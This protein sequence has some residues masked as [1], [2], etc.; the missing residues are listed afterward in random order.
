MTDITVTEGD[1]IVVTHETENIGGTTETQDVVLE[2]DG[3]II[4]TD[5]VVSGRAKTPGTKTE[6]LLCWNTSAG[7]AGSYELCC[8]TSDTEDCRTVG[9]LGPVPSSAVLSYNPLTFSVGDSEW[10]DRA[11]PEENMSLTGSFDAVQLSNGGYAVQPSSST[12]NYGATTMPA[13]LEGSSL[14]NFAVEFELEYSDGSTSF[15]VMGADNNGSSQT[16]GVA[17]NFNFS[18]ATPE[19]GQVGFILQD[20]SSNTLYGSPDISPNLD[21]SNK[22]TIVIDVIDSTSNDVDIYIDGVKETVSFALAES[23]SDFGSWDVDMVT[24]G[25][26]D[27]GTYV[28]YYPGKLGTVRWHDRSI[29]GSTL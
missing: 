12:G 23:P 16:V 27:G 20:N 7:D 14:E 24:F 2:R 13:S 22:H 4:D 29:G 19:A 18:T 11:T 10:V 17:L 8:K 5:D 25:I 9:V 28:S 21:D 1:T 15:S 3:T 26:N 6:R